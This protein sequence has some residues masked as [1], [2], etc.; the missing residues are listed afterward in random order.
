MK[1]TIKNL[2]ALIRR[3]KTYIQND[4]EGYKLNVNDL[5]AVKEAIHYLELVEV[6]VSDYNK[7][8]ENNN[9]ENS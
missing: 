4:Y 9:G 2:K 6:A 1:E 7:E 3:Y 8:R 5:K